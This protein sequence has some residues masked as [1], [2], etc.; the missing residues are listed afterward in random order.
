[1]ELTVKSKRKPE[2]QLQE[3][4][5][6]LSEVVKAASLK[7]QVITVHGKKTAVLLSY[8]RYKKLANPKPALYEFFKSSPLFNLELEL[9]E[10]LPEKP[11]EVC[12]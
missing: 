7:P 9:P 5:A 12:L 11:R 8:D 4:K 1:M 2:W 3:A 6:M 10:R